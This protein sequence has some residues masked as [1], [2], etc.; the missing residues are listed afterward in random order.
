MEMQENRE[1][2]LLTLSD[3]Q[4]LKMNGVKEVLSFDEQSLLLSC[5]VGLLQIMGE[6]LR[7]QELDTA[8]GEIAVGG[9]IDGMLYHAGEGQDRRSL[10]RL[11]R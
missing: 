11:L 5:S 4:S 10:R 9:R 3:R 2:Q 7:V 6:G 8:R 1:K